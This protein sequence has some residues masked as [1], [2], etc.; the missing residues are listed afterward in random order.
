MTEPSSVVITLPREAAENGP[1]YRGRA[2]PMQHGPEAGRHH[3]RFSMTG[4]ERALLWLL[5]CY[6]G[7][8]LFMKLVA[9]FV[10]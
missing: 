7:M 1:I 6:E 9:F 8:K 2:H 4:L 10:L 3:L 5:V